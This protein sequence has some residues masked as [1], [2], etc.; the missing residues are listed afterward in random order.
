MTRLIRIALPEA[1]KAVWQDAIEHAITGMD[2]KIAGSDVDDARID[3]LVY[4]IDSGVTDFT[5]YPNLRAI[6]NTWAGVE[7]VVDTLDWPEDVP[8]CRM[9][10]PGLTIGMTE[11]LVAHTL[12]YHV[13]IDRAIGQSARG[14]WEK[15]LPPLASE[16]TVGVM[17]LGQLGQAAAAQLLKLGFRVAGWSR[18]PR[19]LTDVECFDG[20]KG[21]GDMLA[22]SEILIVILPLTP[23]TEDILDARRLA[24]LP[25]GARIINA[26]RG[27]LIDDDA[28][29]AALESGQVGHATLDVFR[30]E[31]LPEDHPYWRH[32]R[33]TVTPHIAAETRPDSAARTIAEQ[34]ARDMAG[35]KLKFVVDRERGY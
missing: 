29:L 33:V 24:L 22:R 14:E 1:Q 11:Y 5:R 35:Q 13:D 16:R 15:W 26:G 32:D 21:L 10:E 30:K 25:R 8:F 2:V 9:V 23:E 27:A 31:P 20:P 7:A 12:R 34:I 6:L 28:L 18:T 3:Y 4:N 19:E 17:G